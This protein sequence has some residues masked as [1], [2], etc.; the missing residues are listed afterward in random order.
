[1]R[2]VRRLLAAAAVLTT[3]L[4]TAC[5][6][7]A[8]TAPSPSPV[9]TTPIET[10]Q[11]R[12]QRLAYEAAEKAYRT[13]RTEFRRVTESGGAKEATPVMKENAGGEYLRELTEDIKAYK[14][15]GYRTEGGEVL[16]YVRRGG[17]EA[18]SLILVACEDDRKVRTVDT[19]GKVIAKGDV[20]ILD[21]E[22]RK[23]KSRWRVWSG[24]SREATSCS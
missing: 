9:A 16:A 21:L 22:V 3:L 12:E 20:L 17:F 5:T 14:S 6:P 23:V 24:Q 1:M 13:F 11:E 4:T 2:T 19:A 8:G 15:V 18:E 10:D 7:D